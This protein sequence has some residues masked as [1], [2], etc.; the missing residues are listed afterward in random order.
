MAASSAMGPEPR[1]SMSKLAQ[2]KRDGEWNVWSAMSV[3][4]SSEKA[5]PPKG[6]ASG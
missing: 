2:S 5:Q 4:G 3:Q 6:G 1:V